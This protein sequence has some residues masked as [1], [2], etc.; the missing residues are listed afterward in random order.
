MNLSAP[1]NLIFLISLVI[2]IIG[3]LMALGVLPF[4]LPLATEW[5]MTIAYALLAAGC[6]LKGI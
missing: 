6:L 5:I 3:V 1:T 4:A 2:A